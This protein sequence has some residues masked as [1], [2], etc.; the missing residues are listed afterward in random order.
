M[1]CQQAV[2][3]NNWETRSQFMPYVTEAKR[4]G[5]T[6]GLEEVKVKAD[7]PKNWG[8]TKALIG[9]GIA[10]VG[11]IAADNAGHLDSYADGLLG[12]R[13]QG[14]SSSGSRDA[15][16]RLDTLERKMR[17]CNLQSNTAFYKRTGYIPP[18]CR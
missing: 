2:V 16:A 12:G 1:V 10:V 6:C 5:L 8:K 11:A 18:S 13:D 3:G 14:G 17:S 7:E 15:N 9:L 4:R